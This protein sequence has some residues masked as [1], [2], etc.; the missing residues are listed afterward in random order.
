MNKKMRDLLDRIKAKRDEAKGCSA[1]G[2]AKDI[3]KAKAVVAEMKALQEEY[4]VEK[5]LFEAEKASIPDDAADE[6]KSKAGKGGYEAAVK[7][8]ANAAREGFKGL[9]EGTPSQGGYTVPEDIV[10]RIIKL[11]Q[12]KPSLL[13]LVDYAVKKTLSGQE[14]FQKRSN[15]SGFSPVGEGG[16][17]P[18]VGTPE[19]GRLKWNIQKYA[20]YMTITNE[21]LDDS[22][23]NLVAVIMEWFA[24]NSRVTANN[25]V[26]ATLDSKYEGE[27]APKTVEIN[28]LDD[29][30]RVLNVTL[31]QSFKPTSTIVT[32][33]DGLQWLDTLKDNDGNYILKGN[34][35]DPLQLRLSAGATTVPV[36]VVPN[37]GLPTDDAKGIPVYIGDLKEAAKYYDRKALSI[38]ASD[39]AVVGDMNAYEE[40]LTVYRGIEREDVEL[41][42]DQA[43]VKG[44]IPFP[45]PAGE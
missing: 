25:L 1:D 24:D 17:I 34:P 2:E 10:T 13:D 40:D 30:K 21:V 31:G 23:E 28:G 16:K 27:G 32:N 36:R 11:R 8:F 43:Y 42:D 44:F 41:K 12:D 4:E 15:V 20:G 3:A 35:Q 6:A 45:A 22:D 29:I 33:D 26:L 9:N 37:V 38:K 18:A 19:F 5:A 7:S 39:V 14:T